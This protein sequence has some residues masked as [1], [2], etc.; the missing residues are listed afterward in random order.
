[1]VA[2]ILITHLEL[3]HNVQHD[4]DELQINWSTTK[5]S[6]EEALQCNR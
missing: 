5:E 4:V 2:T 6:V 3:P 1:M